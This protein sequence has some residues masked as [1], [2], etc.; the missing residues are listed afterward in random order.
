M[1]CLRVYGH[2]D[3]LPPPYC[4]CSNALT[5]EQLHRIE[6]N[7]KKAQ[8]RLQAKRSSE[9][10]RP[11]QLMKETESAFHPPQPKHPST[12]SN[13][14]LQPAAIATRIIRNP[15]SSHHSGHPTF[16]PPISQSA[17]TIRLPPHLPTISNLLP[18]ASAHKPALSFTST[19]SS[20]SASAAVPSKSSA[21]GA[22]ATVQYVPL[23]EKIK[24]D[25]VVTT[26]NNFKVTIPYDASVIEIFKKMKTRS[27]G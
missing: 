17:S 8:E 12:Q 13:N 21:P 4:A 26:R 23:K 25:F 6:Q 24:A 9:C 1:L 22:S 10:N 16:R 19:Q 2:D 7:K 11:P 18:H 15:S 3:P 27:Y 20:S 5:A 14:V